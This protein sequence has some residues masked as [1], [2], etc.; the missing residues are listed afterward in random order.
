MLVT[1]ASW[2]GVSD[3][4]SERG[5]NVIIVKA[6][7]GFTI[8]ILGLQIRDRVRSKHSFVIRRSHSP[9]YIQATK[10]YRVAA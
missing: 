9:S 10:I 8:R 2:K 3:T 6:L 7:I 5:P 1:A 4:Y